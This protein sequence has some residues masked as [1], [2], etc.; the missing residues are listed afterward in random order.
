MLAAVAIAAPITPILGIRIR[1]NTKLN[2]TMERVLASS[3]FC[4]PVIVSRAPV[5]PAPALTS[6]PAART[7]KAVPCGEASPKHVEKF[8]SENCDARE[9]SERGRASVHLHSPVQSALRTTPNRA[10]AC[11]GK[12]E[13]HFLA[14]AHFYIWMALQDLVK[15]GR[16][17][18][19]GTDS[20]KGWWTPVYEIA[21]PRQTFFPL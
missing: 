14:I 9:H 7:S 15:P 3:H 11:H 10:A 2:A 13:A 16:A 19:H 1:F 6:G 21:L 18:S 4:L 12:K 17:A 8:G 20:H 5:G